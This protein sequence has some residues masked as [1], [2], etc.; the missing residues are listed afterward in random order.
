MNKPYPLLVAMMAFLVAACSAPRQMVDTAVVPASQ[1]ATVKLDTEGDG[2]ERSF[3]ILKVDDQMTN[4]ACL[5]IGPRC[6]PS[7]VTVAP[8]RH[9]LEIEYRFGDRRARIKLP[10]ETRAGRTYVVRKAVN[11]RNEEFT[12]TISASG[13][14]PG[15]QRR[16]EDS[17]KV[18]VE[19]AD[20][21][22]ASRQ[23]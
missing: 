11:G 2:W 13:A 14:S 19:E 6:W 4:P 5:M 21:E 9:I 18:W 22:K 17:V 10:A 1:Q 20:A 3:V 15:M 7:Q 8:G 12:A 23:N 16:I